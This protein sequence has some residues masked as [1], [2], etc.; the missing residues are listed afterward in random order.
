MRGKV[1]D[2]SLPE[3]VD[4]VDIIISEWMGYCLFYESMLNTVIYARDKWLV[5]CYLK[6]EIVH[7]NSILSLSPLPPS[8][9]P[10]NPFLSLC[11]FVFR[12]YFT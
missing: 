9:P 10:Q 6:L 1:E 12:L 4:K 2:V 3:G 5:S 7:L 11:G 8:L